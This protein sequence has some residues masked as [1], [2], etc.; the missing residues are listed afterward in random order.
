MGGKSN[1][2]THLLTHRQFMAGDSFQSIPEIVCYRQCPGKGMS[3][4][5]TL[6]SFEG[7]E[8]D[9]RSGRHECWE[10]VIVAF[11]N[12]VHLGFT[13]CSLDATAAV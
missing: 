4:A 10:T 1:L 11:H 7:E 6:D 2:D 13:Y 3:F 5:L 9:W 12:S 8:T